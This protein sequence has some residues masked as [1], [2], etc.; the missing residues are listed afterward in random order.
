MSHALFYLPPASAAFFYL[1]RLLEMGT[2]RRVIPGQI[3]EKS[4]LRFFIAIG[5]LVFCASVAEYVL[6]RNGRI[7]WPL[8]AVGWVVGL[9]SVWIRRMA[10]AALGRFWSLHVEIREEHEFVQNGPFRFVRHPAYFSMLLEL[11]SVPLIC[12]AYFS[13]LA[14]PLFFV[15]AL[16]RRIRIEE[17]ALVDK[18]G[19]P[20]RE[21]QRTKPALFPRLW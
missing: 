10:I 16:L 7:F 21:Y 14:I 6:L 9:A 17:A 13:L 11:L 20:Y 19:E 12:G 5:T 8:F 4:T 2:N 15:P 3:H 1:M 18:F